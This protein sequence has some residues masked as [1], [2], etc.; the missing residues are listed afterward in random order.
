MNLVRQEFR[1]SDLDFAAALTYDAARLLLEKALSDLDVLC[2]AMY[3]DLTE[4]GDAYS[5][6]TLLRHL[7]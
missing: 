5:V 2:V 1:E 7:A 3:V 4:V 6:S